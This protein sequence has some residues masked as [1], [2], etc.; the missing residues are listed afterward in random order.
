VIRDVKFDFREDLKSRNQM[1]RK[2]EIPN[3][4]TGFSAHTSARVNIV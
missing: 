2:I 1:D 4:I 3:L